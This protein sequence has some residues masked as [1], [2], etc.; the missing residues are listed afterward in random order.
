MRPVVLLDTKYASDR[1]APP[2][3]DA[4]CPHLEF[5]V[6]LD[7]ASRRY[8]GI[9]SGL[10]FRERKV[11]SS[12]Q[13][14]KSEER[15]FLPSLWKFVAHESERVCFNAVSTRPSAGNRPRI[16]S[17]S[18][19]RTVVRLSVMIT[20]SRRRPAACPSAE[21]TETRTRLGWPTR[22]RLVEIMATMV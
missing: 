6:V 19:S 4:R 9:R 1:S 7:G 22:A 18:D 5:D 8:N 13:Y 3:D 20:E 14:A 2:G 16:E 15:D 12:L 11:V 10:R 21:F 17:I